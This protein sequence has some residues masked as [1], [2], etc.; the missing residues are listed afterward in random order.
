MFFLLNIFYFRVCF[1]RWA[2]WDSLTEWKGFLHFLCGLWWVTMGWI[3][4]NGVLFGA[5]NIDIEKSFLGSFTLIWRVSVSAW[6]SSESWTNIFYI[7]IEFFKALQ[8]NLEAPERRP[9]RLKTCPRQANFHTL[10]EQ[11]RENILDFIRSLTQKKSF[12]NKNLCS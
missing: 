1:I 3:V 10:L 8:K 7:N 9:D 4:N 12:I 6:E 5:P 11:I 2:L